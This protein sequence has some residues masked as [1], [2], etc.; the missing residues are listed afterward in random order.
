MCGIPLRI[1]FARIVVLAALAAIPATR[2]VAQS[3]QPSPAPPAKARQSTAV[4]PPATMR[5]V[6]ADTVREDAW[7][8]L[9]DG[10]AE[11]DADRRAQAISALGAIGNLPEVVRLVEGGLHDKSVTVREMAATTLGS[12][13]S[14]S[15]IPRLREALDGSAAV[16]FAAAQ[17]LSAMGDNSGEGIFI[18]ILQGDRK[19]SSGTVG[20][21]LHYAHEELH[22]PKALAELGAQQAAGTFLGPAGFGVTVVEELAKDKA[23]PARAVSA[24]LLGSHMD[25]DSRNALEQALA[26]KSWVVRATAAEALG[27]GHS[28]SSVGK[29]A[30]LLK[31]QHYET[32]YKA[33]AAI[34]R[35]TSGQ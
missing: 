19:V 11:K 21:G 15:S 23:A 1:P 7:K 18:E 6:S 25:A 9:T 30:P 16:S 12:M 35:L 27:A 22:D 13:K 10:V 2:L 31:D 4:S 29:L 26:D 8:C 33:A 34:I 24:R 32:R 14:R 20:V 17:A 28:A 5:P 3:R